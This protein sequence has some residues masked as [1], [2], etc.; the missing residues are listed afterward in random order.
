[1]DT[2]FAKDTSGAGEEK[3]LKKV[4][5]P[6][7]PSDWS[8]DGHFLLYYTTNTPK[9]GADLW[10]LPLEG[11]HKPVL[12][13]GTEANEGAGVFSPDMHWIAYVSNESGRNEVY[14]RPF[15]PSGPSGAP[16]LGDGIWPVS[17]D[18]A[19]G[20]VSWRDHGKEIFFGAPDGGSMA[21]D[22]SR[23]PAQMSVPRPLAN[24]LNLKIA[25]MSGVIA[26]DGKRWLV[27]VAQ[28]NGVQPFTVVLNW[29]VLLRR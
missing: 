20:F 23:G 13:L 27:S 7:V 29:Q 15:I 28:K 18:G 2:L 9:T 22:I 11:D 6:I 21:V 5:Q 4:G 16:V 17:R 24:I 10:L 12:L 1:L 19:I 26:P 3:E 8:P 25:P 14:V